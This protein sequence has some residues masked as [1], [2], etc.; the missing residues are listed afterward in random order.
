MPGISGPAVTIVRWRVASSWS[1][2]ASSPL[3][4][5]AIRLA[6]P[7]AFTFAV[8]EMQPAAPRGIASLRCASLAGKTANPGNEVMT[9]RVLSQ[10]PELSLSPTTVPGKSRS[11][12]SIRDSD[13]P[14]PAI[15]GIW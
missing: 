13:H 7:E 14:A 2:V 4:R 10:S 15:C 11:R 3:R 1:A 5:A 8:A 12:R 9:A 6:M